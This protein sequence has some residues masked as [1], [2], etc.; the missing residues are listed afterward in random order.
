MGQSHI[1]SFE[2]F[3]FPWMLNKAL[4][5]KQMSRIP[6]FQQ[7]IYC[8]P[9]KIHCKDNATHANIYRSSDELMKS[10]KDC[11]EKWE[12]Y[13]EQEGTWFPSRHSSWNI[14]TLPVLHCGPSSAIG[15]QLVVFL[16]STLFNSERLCPRPS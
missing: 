4:K 2:D 9:K 13:T 14:L 1:E 8:S 15:D 10:V 16:A 6:G 11:W 5:K 12:N 7:G 3:F